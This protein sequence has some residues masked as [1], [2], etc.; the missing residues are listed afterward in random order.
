MAK[1]TKPNTAKTDS[2][3]AENTSIELTIPK[4]EVIS[5]LEHTLKRLQSS[6]KLDGF[7]KGKVPLS[8]VRRQLGDTRIIEEALPRAAREAYASAIKKEQ[9]TPVTPPELEPIKTPWNESWKVRATFAERPTVTIKGY[10][11]TVKK[12]NKS[13][14]P[15]EKK[16]DA[17]SEKRERLSHI[18][19]ALITAHGPKIPE[20][21]LKYEVQE[22]LRSIQYQLQSVK[23]SLEDF[24]KETGQSYDEF[25]T[26]L[27]ARTLGTVQLQLVLHAI[28][29]AEKLSAD[30]SAIDAHIKNLKL[31]KSSIS[32]HQREHIAQQLVQEQ[33]TDHLLS[34]K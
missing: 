33:L 7:R 21:L 3:L 29:E 31:D 20:A 28:V 23:R 15:S 4:L 11:T 26:G 18:Y 6:V 32:P 5:A 34:I 22:E 30:A 16:L 8:M 14:K 27:T 9:L 10:K 13:F 17:A 2:P 1:Q 25:A 19:Q 24:L 12:A